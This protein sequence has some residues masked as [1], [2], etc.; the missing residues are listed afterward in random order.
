MLADGCAIRQQH[1]LDEAAYDSFSSLVESGPG[2]GASRKA[3]DDAAVY[4]LGT[5]A[6]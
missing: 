1:P 2:L 5:G 4:N 6:G 3:N